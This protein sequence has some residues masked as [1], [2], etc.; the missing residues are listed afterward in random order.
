MA[1]GAAVVFACAL[2][3]APAAAPAGQG[4]TPIGGSNKPKLVF[5][6]ARVIS[7]G[8]VTPGQLETI[9]VSHMPPRTNVRVLIEPPPTTPECGEL[10]FC[11][12]AKTTPAPG[13]PPYRTS[14]K[15]RALLAFVMPSSYFVETDPFRPREGHLSNFAN[16]Q[17]VH[18]DVDG[19]R[20]SK[21]V[22]RVGFGF[23][24]AVVQLPPA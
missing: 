12:P 5:L 6:K 24:R 19:T 13:S 11:D 23:A 14:G 3:A 20:R 8:V 15:G 7:D 9:A 1:G 10:Y 21:R 16:G 22:R 17:A 2:L 18:I 4:V